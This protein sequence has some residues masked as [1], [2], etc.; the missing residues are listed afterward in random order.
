[1]NIKKKYILIIIIL[2]LCLFQ[3]ISYAEPIEQTEHRTIIVGDDKAYPPYSFIDAKGM[4]TGFSIELVQA[5]ARVMNIDVE[6]RLDEWKNVRTALE[7][8]EIDAVSGMFFSNDREQLYLFTAKHSVALGDIFTRKDTYIDSWEE[9][10]GK[11]VVVQKDDIVHEFLESQDLGIDFITVDTVGYGLILVASGRYDYAA[12]LRPT[13]GYAIEKQRLSNLRPANIHTLQQDYCIAVRRENEKLR[14]TFNIGLQILKST[15]EYQRIYDKWLGVYEEKNFYERIKKYAWMIWIATG[16]FGV[17]VTGVAVLRHQVKVKTKELQKANDELMDSHRKLSL[18]KDEVEASYEELIATEEELRSQ[19]AQIIESEQKLKDSEQYTQSIIKALPDLLFV[20]SNEGRFIDCQGGNKN[21]LLVPAEIFIG[22]KLEDVMPKEIANTA[23]E[24]IKRLRAGSELEILEYSLPTPGG[25][26]E[27]ET[28][29]VKN[30]E[31]SIVAISRDITDRKTYE[32]NLTYISEHDELTGLYNRRFFEND[33]GRERVSLDYPVAVLSFD[34]NGLKIINDTLGHAKGDQLLI[35]SADI[36]KRALPPEAV[37][38]RIGGDEFI[39]ILDN[40]D[41]KKAKDIM[42]LVELELDEYNKNNKMF[43]ISIAMGL[44]VE[45]IPGEGIARALNEAD[46]N[47]YRQKLMQ[48]KSSRNQIIQSLM[49]VLSVKDYITQGHSDRM[50]DTIVK[51]GEALELHPK[52]IANLNLLAQVHDL[53]KIGIPDSIL[54]KEGPLTQEEWTLMRQHS[55]K[56][57]R[58]A[59]NTPDLVDV[60]EFILKHHE[61][62]DGS[63]YPLNLKEKEI[64]IEC[65]MLSIVDAYDAMTNDR[66]YRKGIDKQEAFEELERCKGTHFDPDLVD[67][68]IDIES[69]QI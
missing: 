45:T 59:M 56:G 53:G 4:P 34:V 38:A 21:E 26:T 6:F 5:I 41:E 22:K 18:S 17:L 23:Y 27:Y 50:S 12:M 49:A 19:Y 48:A 37:V 55:E 69:L 25:K 54:F 44:S 67:L 7:K 65:R 66:P 13:G 47:M 42:D 31:K 20:L 16:A 64:P 24:K 43:P 1:M 2:L 10:R 40:T 36:I 3:P 9:L 61:K 52:R 30:G 33:L 46:E 8:G 32:K 35:S 51:M 63:G 58:I 14:D 62:W 28:R 15:G 11:Q 29:M 68:F 60:A 39:G 57:Y